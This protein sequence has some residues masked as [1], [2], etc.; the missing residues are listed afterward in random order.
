MTGS[1]VIIDRHNLG[2][3]ILALELG[4]T[5]LLV[6]IAKRF[7]IMFGSSVYA[8]IFVTNAIGHKAVLHDCPPSHFHKCLPQEVHELLWWLGPSISPSLAAFLPSASP[9]YSTHLTEHKLLSMPSLRQDRPA[10]LERRALPIWMVITGKV[11]SKV[12]SSSLMAGRYYS[13][14]YIDGTWLWSYTCYSHYIVNLFFPDGPV[15]VFV[16]VL[17]TGPPK[18]SNH[19]K[20]RMLAKELLSEARGATFVP[21]STEAEKALAKIY[22]GIFHLVESE[23]S[24]SDNFF[25][26]GGTSIDVIRLKCE[27][28]AHFGLPEIPTI[29][30]LKHPVVSTLANYV[31]ASLSKDSRTEEYDPIVPLQLTGNKTPIFVHPGVGEPGHPFFTSMDEMVSCYAAAVKRTQATGPYTIAGYS[32]GGIVAFE[33]AKRLEAMAWTIDKQLEVVWKL[34]PPERL[35]E[36]RLTA[37]KL[38]HWVDIAGSMIECGKDYNSSGSVSAVDV[39]YAI[40]LRGSMADWLNNQLKPWSGFSCGEAS[41]TDVPGQHYMLMDFDHVPQFQKIFHSR[42][43]AHGL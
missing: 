6:K 18:L 29:Q 4:E 20:E 41:Y 28:E 32:Y 17:G 3:S 30:I 27:G 10:L 22:A 39:F 33:V 5:H 11:S 13:A 1:K 40:P 34:S 42:L 8:H 43:E 16:L 19:L 38:D 14:D 7:E 31:N 24:A 21:P 36:L 37:G 9:P 25:E 15:S 23:M 26:L 2:Y 35:V 12:H